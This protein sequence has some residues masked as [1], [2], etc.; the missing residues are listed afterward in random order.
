[1]Q[2]TII[3]ILTIITFLYPKTIRDIIV[4]GNKQIKQSEILDSLNHSVGDTINQ[5]LIDQDYKKLLSISKIENVMITP[6]DSIYYIIIQ[7]KKNIQVRPLINKDETLGWSYGLAIKF[8]KINNNPQSVDI[9]ATGGKIENYFIDYVHD[10]ID[11][12]NN[13]FSN[14][15][16]HSNFTDIEN[17]YIINESGINAYYTLN[18][19]VN[20][21][22]ELGIGIDFIKSYIKY[23]N[24]NNQSEKISHI[25]PNLYYKIVTNNKTIYNNLFSINT[26]YMIFNS[27]NYK[28]YISFN[29]LNLLT[30]PLNNNKFSPRIVFKKNLILNSSKNIPINKILYLGGENFVR[31]YDPYPDANP[32]E[33]QNKIKWN[34][35]AISSVQLEIPIQYNEYFNTEMLF[36]IDYGLGSND[37]TTF[38]LNNKLYGYGVGFRYN[39]LNIGGADMC[40]GLNPYDGSK[41]FHFI[42][43]FKNF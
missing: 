33:A 10:N 8:N 37:Y 22:V 4:V 23:N 31:G 12:Q 36:F 1:M 7:E 32:M 28:N 2:K 20:K 41:T 25:S 14:N 24:S 42:A 9:G 19:I 16:F 34:N 15:L 3:F 29:I 38:N 30:L 35:I 39:I 18:H 13:I 17:T 26:A 6:I 21:N 5:T 40:V 43:N 11:N 27:S